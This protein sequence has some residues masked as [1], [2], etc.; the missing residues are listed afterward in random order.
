MRVQASSTTSTMTLGSRAAAS[1]PTSRPARGSSS[2]S[3]DRLRDPDQGSVPMPTS[4]NGTMVTSMVPRRRRPV[5]GQ[6][7]PLWRL[8]G[9]SVGSHL[10]A[11]DVRPARMRAE[12]RQGRGGRR[13]SSRHA[14]R[15]P[16][17]R[18]AA[19]LVCRVPRGALPGGRSMRESSGGTRRRFSAGPEPW[20][21][22]IG[23]GPGRLVTVGSMPVESARWKS[24]PGPGI[25]PGFRFSVRS[26]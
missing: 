21:S 3:A 10:V 25:D 6:R 9:A 1:T 20:E 4:R 13:R 2:R 14:R 18:G 26:L 19:A 22:A 12:A 5:K 16:R 8:G 23:H 7:G 24:P 11:V 17:A 15:R